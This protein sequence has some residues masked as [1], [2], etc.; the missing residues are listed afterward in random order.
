MG[1]VTRV[2]SSLQEMVGAMA[3]DVARRC[4][5][6]LR[7]RKFTTATLARTFVFGFLSHPRASD[8]QLAQV[9][10]LFG[11]HLTTQALE[12]RFTPRLAAFLEALFREASGRV[13]GA[14][15]ALAPILE[16]FAAVY[17]LDSTVE[18][19]PEQQR[20]RFP[21]CGGSH[22]G[23]RAAMKLQ[24]LWELRGGALQAVRVE[25]GRHCDYKTPL[26]A[27]PPTPGSLAGRPGA[28]GALRMAS[29][30]P[31]GSNWCRARCQWVR[32]GLK[33]MTGPMPLQ[34][35]SALT[36]RAL[37]EVLTG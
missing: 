8:E 6:V 26:Q 17:L 12:Q 19:L 25:A 37:H 22:G 7:R 32:R 9:A 1:I 16:R 36:N 2:A 5:V 13:I 33:Y 4:P 35:H 27:A 31:R 14:Q 30:R 24:V 34:S 11:V 18:S 3:E 28:C 23:G 21:G 29:I 10:G 20:D 15:A